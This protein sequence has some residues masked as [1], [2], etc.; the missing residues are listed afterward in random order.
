MEAAASGVLCKV[1]AEPGRGPALPGPPALGPGSSDVSLHPPLQGPAG[2]GVLG[3]GL[4]MVGGGGRGLAR[5]I[6]LHVA[7]LLAA[8]ADAAV[9]LRVQEGAA[10]AERAPLE[11]PLTELDG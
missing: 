6:E 9:T 5:L 8:A 1:S 11:L 3:R 10:V 7:V 4:G 2:V